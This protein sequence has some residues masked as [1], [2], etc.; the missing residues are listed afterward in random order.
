MSIR[1]LWER[2]EWGKKGRNGAWRDNVN[3][4]HPNPPAPPPAASAINSQWLIGNA[5]EKSTGM[6]SSDGSRV[7]PLI[8]NAGEKSMGM[9]SPDG[10][11]VVLLIVKSLGTLMDLKWCH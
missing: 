11:R 7:V 8:G 10:S 1:H 4:S 6:L 9:S 5:G 2:Q 3:L